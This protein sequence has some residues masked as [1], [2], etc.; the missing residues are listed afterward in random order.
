MDN[1][2]TVNDLLDIGAII[3]IDDIKHEIVIIQTEF[4]ITD[5]NTPIRICDLFVNQDNELSI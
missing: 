1:T 5:Q 2:V 3:N 4:V